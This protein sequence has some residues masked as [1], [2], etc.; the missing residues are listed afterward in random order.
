[1]C[2]SEL[3]IDGLRSAAD[4]KSA[5]ANILNLFLLALQLE[6]IK[7]DSHPKPGSGTCTS[8]PWPDSEVVTFGASEF[9]H[10]LARF[11]LGTVL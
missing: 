6:P 2:P 11:R 3:F 9:V 4:S 7:I 10:A 8:R 5:A 1:V